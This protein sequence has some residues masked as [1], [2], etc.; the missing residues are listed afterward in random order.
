MLMKFIA[1]ALLIFH[2]II[3]ML[4]GLSW[5]RSLFGHAPSPSATFWM[6][7][8]SVGTI[9]YALSSNYSWRVYALA[10]ANRRA[11]EAGVGTLVLF[12]VLPFAILLLNFVS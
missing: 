12:S 10:V 1:L 4:I 8:L 2:G 9:W 11:A 3:D 6:G 5:Y 7:I